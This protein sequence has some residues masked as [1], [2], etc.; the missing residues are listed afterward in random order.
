VCQKP[1]Y[2]RIKTEVQ[3]SSSVFYYPKLLVR[4]E[5]ADPSLTTEDF[6][7]LY[8]GFVFQ[9][10][11]KPYWTSQEEQELLP[12]YQSKK[13]K[14]EDYDKIIQLA[15]RAIDKF[16]FDLRQMNFLAYIYHL[17]GNDLMAGQ[18]SYKL[19]GII[20]AILSSGDGKKCETGYHVITVSHEYVILNIFEATV[21]SQALKNGCDYFKLR[22]KKNIYFDI[23]QFFGKGF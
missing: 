14:E 22:G 19:N 21:V 2:E 15:T 17:K 1:D 4:Y 23:S 8:Y 20:Q 6:R 12:Y 9:E 7:Y 11:Y 10:D 18:I 16:P 13:L 5:L 3:D